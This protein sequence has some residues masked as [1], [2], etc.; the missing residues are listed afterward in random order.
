M[1][2]YII[3]DVQIH[4]PKGYEEYRKLV[5]P[6]LQKYGAKFVARGGKVD[7]LEG[8]WNPSRL[9]ILEFDSAEKARQFYHSD[10]YRPAK[11]VRQK[12]STAN[13]IVVEGV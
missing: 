4:D 7:V 3:A 11:A 2:A 8:K 10:E 13:F 5:G 1:P 12:T 6:A 9:V